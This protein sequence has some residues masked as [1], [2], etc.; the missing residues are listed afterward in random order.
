MSQYGLLVIAHGSR[1]EKW[2]AAID[3][4]VDQ[5]RVD[6]P[7]EVGYLELVP[8]RRIEDGVRSLE[9]RGVD[10]IIVAPLF[11]TMGSA[12]ANEIQY[13]LGLIERP[14]IPTDLAPIATK[15]SFIWNAPLEDHPTVLEIVEERAREMSRNARQEV[16]LL[17]GHGC[18]H[19]RL[20]KRWD[21]LLMNIGR[22]LV[23]RVG[24]KSCSFATL[25]SGRWAEQAKRL[26]SSDR[27]IVVPIFVSEGY[28][29]RQAIPRELA[30]VDC[31]YEG[32]TL[33]PHPLISKWIEQTVVQTFKKMID[34]TE[35]MH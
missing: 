24:F 16:V 13:A 5:A 33:L 11:M 14:A 7:R 30:D 21:R 26:A 10:Q 35:T 28:F 29:T 6:I 20:E 19:P 15:A 25:S 22:R 12:H 32:K 17:V 3:Q 1:D 18:K 31:A 34:E 9:R 23:K 2:I 8:G 27:L 4:A